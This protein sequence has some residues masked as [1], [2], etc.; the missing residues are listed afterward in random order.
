MKPQIL[1]IVGIVSVIIISGCT[2]TGQVVGPEQCRDVQEAYQDCRMVEVPY[3]EGECDTIPYTDQECV[4]EQLEYSSTDDDMRTEKVCVSQHQECKDKFSDASGICTGY[5]MVCDEYKETYA[6]DLK[7]I[8]TEKGIWFFNW[9]RDC[10]SGEPS[11]AIDEPTIHSGVSYELETKVTK[12]F[13]TDIT[14]DADGE[15]FLYVEFIHI[16]ERQVCRDVIKY[17]DPCSGTKTEEQCETKYRT[18]QKCD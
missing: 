7:N 15:E 10:E 16:P 17:R 4:Y 13:T 14:Y 9:M 6:F 2:Q 12:T 3:Q 1:L 18:V 8:D 11:C 5:V